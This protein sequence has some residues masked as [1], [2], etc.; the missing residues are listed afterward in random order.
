MFLKD[1]TFKLTPVI[2]NLDF[3]QPM[4]ASL[5]FSVASSRV[6]PSE[7]Q[8]GMSVHSAT[9]FPSSSFSKVR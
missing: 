4:M 6:S 2:F 8:P 3:K 1:G 5:M 7:K 9:Y